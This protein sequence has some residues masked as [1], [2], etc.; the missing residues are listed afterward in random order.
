MAVQSACLQIH[1]KEREIVKHVTC[2]N[3]LVEFD[4]IE[5]DRLVFDQ[6]DIT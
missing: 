4:R 3:R 1:Q 6:D 5:Q 2:R